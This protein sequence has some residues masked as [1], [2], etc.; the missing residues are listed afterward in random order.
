MLWKCCTQYANKFRKLGSGHRT[1]KG[2]FIP[3]PK[4]GN[5]KEYSNYHTIALIS[6]PSKVMIKILQARLQQYMNQELPHVPAGFQRGRGNRD[7]ITDICCIIEKAREFQENISLCYTDYIKVFDCVNYNKSWAILKEMAVP[8]PPY[9]SLRN[10]YVGQEAIRTG[11][12]T[13]DWFKIGSTRLYILTLL[14]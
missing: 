5:A 3:V 14:I 12:G 6:H 7:Q 1:R 11:H 10:L 8:K 4:R 2:V 13:M 9:L